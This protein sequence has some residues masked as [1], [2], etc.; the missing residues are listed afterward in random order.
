M[1]RIRSV[2]LLLALVLLVPMGLLVQRAL[3]SVALERRVSH[4]AVAERLVDEMERE[5]SRFLRSEDERKIDDERFVSAG[6]G[7]DGV[8]LGWFQVDSGGSFAQ[9]RTTGV[10]DAELEALVTR[11]LRFEKISSPPAAAQQAPGTTREFQVGKREL[12]EGLA[13]LSGIPGEKKQVSPY[14]ALQSLNKGVRMRSERQ[15]KRAASPE[16]L[17][18]RAPEPAADEFA[19][20]LP[21]TEIAERRL[22]ASAGAL[23]GSSVTKMADAD[24]RSNARGIAVAE[25][26]EIASSEP[27]IEVHPMEGRLID[28]EHLLLYRRVERGDRSH[29]QGLVLALPALFSRLDAAVV[30]EGELAGFVDRDFFVEGAEPESDRG[31]D[32]YRY[33]HRFAD[34]FAALNIRLDL[35]PL[36]DVGGADFVY[37]ISLLLLVTGTLGLY[38]VYRMVAVTVRFA[39]RRSNFVAAVTHELKTP[40]T[41][42]RMYSEMLR[43]DMVEDDDKRRVYYAT[44]TA[45]SERLS[46]LIDNVLEFSR[47]EQGTRE[48]NLVVGA[49]GPV[50]DEAAAMLEPHAREVGFRIDVEVEEG[51]PPVAFDRDAVVQVVFNLVE[52]ALKYARDAGDRV[53]TIRCARAGDGVLLAV[54]DRGPGVPG[55]HVSQIFEPFYRG[56]DELTRTAKGTGIGLALV[57]GLAD[58]MG[59]AVVGRNLA[60]GGFE[61]ALTFRVPLAN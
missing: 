52:N 8:V 42:I 45:E 2:F 51:L 29:R 33:R 13:V 3:E 15:V 32:V 5:L 23:L 54:R 38:A 47:L 1:R 20:S 30:G 4:R 16:R 22:Q 7:G 46:R 14:D 55:N 61:V 53:V 35:A 39:E 6:G 27:A 43:D 56:G 60:D 19:M 57:K 37:A 25:A 17:L 26:E 36:P 49:I 12:S 31:A 24:S 41:A 34:P 40:L 58:A 59:A 28:G 11:G 50:V 21:A 44:I 48:T 18:A 9:A 10:V